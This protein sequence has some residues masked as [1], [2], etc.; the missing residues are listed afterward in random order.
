MES[1]EVKEMPISYSREI[2]LSFCAVA[3]EIS[4]QVKK[5]LE[6]II[7]VAEE[8]GYPYELVITTHIPVDVKSDKIKFIN[9]AFTTPGAGKQLAYIHSNGNYLIIFNPYNIYSPET[10]DVVHSFL[11]KR[12]KRA[13][14]YNLIVISRDLLDK[15]GGWRDLREYEDIDLLARIAAEGGIVAFPA[16]RYDS[17]L[18]RVP[19]KESFIDRFLNFRDAII[20]CN[21]GLKDIKIFHIEPF[22]VSFISL[23]LSKLS[24]TK[25]YKFKENNRIIVMEGIMESLILKDFENYFIPVTIPKLHISSTELNY[26]EKRSYLWNKVNKSIMEIIQVSDN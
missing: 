24:R 22:Y 4:D 7:N 1:Y 19:D 18:Y 23:L 20:S 8:I 6:S 3:D 2:K 15:T 26:M 25:P 13:L 21:F 5:S 10:S 16:E 14:I 17:L 12:E 9:E 11:E